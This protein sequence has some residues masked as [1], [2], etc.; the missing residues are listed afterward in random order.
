MLVKKFISLLIIFV[1][2]VSCS[3]HDALAQRQ[4]LVRKHLKRLKKEEGAI[5]LV[6]GSN[7]YEGN[8][9]IFHNGKWGNICDDEWDKYEAEIVC[10]QLNF[11]KGG[12]ATHGGMFGKA[13][14]KFWMDN[15]YCTGR[16]TE[17]SAW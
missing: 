7:D 10:N 1:T 2:F 5:K 8:V 9:E 12:K 3:H 4:K 6:G 14:R 13:R 16:E 17:L 11:T 15:L